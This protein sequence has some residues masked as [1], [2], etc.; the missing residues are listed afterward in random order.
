MRRKHH[1]PASALNI[2][3]PTANLNVVANELQKVISDLVIESCGYCEQH[4]KTKLVHNND[5]NSQEII[6]PVTKTSYGH[7]AYSKFIPVIQVPGVVV[8]TRQQELEKK[9][10]DRSGK[11]FNIASLAYYYHYV[12]D[13][14]FSRHYN[15]VPCKLIYILYKYPGVCI[16]IHFVDY[17]LI[18]F[19]I[20]KMQIMPIPHVT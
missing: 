13:G 14:C 4:G 11:W 9:D 15:V 12:Y 7:S 17:D 20:Y 3:D 8:I 16:Y 19:A 5:S 6:F 18:S 10:S 1:I 2:Q